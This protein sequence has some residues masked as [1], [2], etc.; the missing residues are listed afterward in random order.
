MLQPVS[1][2]QDLTDGMERAIV[3]QARCGDTH[4]L[5]RLYDHYFPRVY[6]YVLAHTGKA[7]EAEDVTED[8]FLRML[9]GISGFRWKQAPF[10]AWLFR[11][12]R[13]QLVS[14]YRRNGVRR[15]ETPIGDS[16]VDTAPDPL[17]RVETRLVFDQVLEASHQL[18]DAQREVIW[19]R[20]AAG[21]S[22]NE[23]ARVLKKREGNV[24]VLQHHAIVRLRKLLSP[25]KAAEESAV[26]EQ[27]RPAVSDDAAF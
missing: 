8:V 11:I 5:A 15:H 9:S 21:L 4:A 25:P 19:L 12:A 10:A 17:S 1:Q 24:K 16:I 18:T 13:N 7:A 22:V 26:R 27:R 2:A 20:F 14:H 3:D 6:H 23:T